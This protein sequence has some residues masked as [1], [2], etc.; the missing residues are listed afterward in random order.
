MSLKNIWHILLI[1]LVFIPLNVAAE[2]N[3]TEVM[4][5]FR[6]NVAHIDPDFSNNS[7]RIG[8][9]VDYLRSLRADSTRTITSVEFCGAA[10]PEGSYALNRYLAGARLASLEKVI[11]SQVYIP[12][13]IIVRNDS[14]IP[15]AFLREQVAA[16][17]LEYKDTVISII[18]EEP[19]LVK[20]PWNGKQIDP[21]HCQAQESQR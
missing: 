16:S 7:Q 3:R 17:N 14:Y 6:V 19:V 11:R 1:L 21:P 5:D 4:V 20:A 2:E 10:S 9:I 15:W 13:S 8:Q 12:D 18:D